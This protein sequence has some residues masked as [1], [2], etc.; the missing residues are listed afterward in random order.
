MSD[1]PNEKVK[2]KKCK[3]TLF[4]AQIL[5]RVYLTIK[6][7]RCKMVNKISYGVEDLQK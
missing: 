7:D 2:C 6:C 5:D 1:S 3:K 4:F